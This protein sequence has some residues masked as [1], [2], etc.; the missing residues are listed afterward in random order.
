MVVRLS[1]QEE[2]DLSRSMEQ[3]ARSLRLYLKSHGWVGCT[4]RGCTVWEKDQFKVL[5]P[6]SDYSDFKS[7]VLEAIEQ[8]QP[9]K[10]VL[11]ENC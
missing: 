8:I 2:G 6:D 9:P 3:G 10:L 4:S 7:R 1:P 5:I 11:W